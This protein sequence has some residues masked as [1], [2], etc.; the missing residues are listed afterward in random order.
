MCLPA[1]DLEQA[2][3]LS[4]PQCH[5]NCRRILSQCDLRP[6]WPPIWD[7]P[8][9]GGEVEGATDPAV[10][11]HVRA[12]TA[13]LDERLGPPRY[14]VEIAV[15]HKKPAGSA[16]WLPDCVYRSRIDRMEISCY[17]SQ[18]ERLAESLAHE[19]V[20]AREPRILGDDF[21]EGM[22]VYY[23]L[24]YCRQRGLNIEWHWNWLR[25]N[26]VRRAELC[27]GVEA[28][29]DHLGTDDFSS[30]R[31]FCSETTF[32]VERWLTSRCDE[33]LRSIV[34]GF[35]ANGSRP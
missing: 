6:D 8:Q 16:V 12:I 25:E 5:Q 26:D 4:P 17:K 24:S 10:A 32:D 11:T 15:F 35:L 30:I 13:Y 9:C 19:L 14:A 3:A 23:S 33:Q 22:A 31:P 21:W 28:V 7:C 2:R 29:T 1:T 27:R 18:P 34:Q 20:H